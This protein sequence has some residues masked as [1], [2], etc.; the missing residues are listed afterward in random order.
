[1]Y[2]HTERSRYFSALFYRSSILNRRNLT[3]D[4]SCYFRIFDFSF[5][6]S[7]IYEFFCFVPWIG[8][9]SIPYQ[10]KPISLRSSVLVLSMFPNRKQIAASMVLTEQC[11]SKRCFFPTDTI[12]H[13]LRLLIL[14]FLLRWFSFRFLILRIKKFRWFYSSMNLHFPGYFSSC[15]YFNRIDRWSVVPSI[16]S[17]FTTF[18]LR[19]F[20]DGWSVASP[21]NLI[22]SNRIESKTPSSSYFSFSHNTSL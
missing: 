16:I 2:V 3:D 13:H 20:E 18:F 9:H 17:F 11:S 8:F 15:T 22:E 6:V 7:N 21:A 12:N 10:M 1:M 14:L 19:H 5:A 4:V